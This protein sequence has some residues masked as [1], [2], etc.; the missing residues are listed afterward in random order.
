MKIRKVCV[1]GWLTRSE[2]MDDGFGGG[3]GGDGVGGLGGADASSWSTAGVGAEAGNRRRRAT[4]FVVVFVD[5]DGVGVSLL[6]S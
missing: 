1:G 4:G 6:F 2:R 5:V 3:T